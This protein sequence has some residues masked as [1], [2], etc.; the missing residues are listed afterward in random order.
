VGLKRLGE[1]LAN[2]E[3][4]I[5]LRPD[6]IDARRYHCIVL[7]QSG[8]YNEA[9]HSYDHVV[10]LTPNDVHA[11]H[12][13]GH[14]LERL[15]RLVEALQCYER[16]VE[17]APDFADAHNRHIRVLNKLGR[18]DEALVH[19]RGA[20]K[21]SP[22]PKFFYLEGLCLYELG[23]YE[24]AYTAGKHIDPV[25][26]GKDLDHHEF[27]SFICGK[28]NRR[29]EGQLHGGIALRLKDAS[30]QGNKYYAIPTHP[31]ADPQSGRKVISYTLYGAQ[32]R[33]C[34][35]AIA[36]CNAAAALLPD[37]SCR[38]YVDASVP[39]DVLRR[40]RAKGAEVIMVDDT[41]KAT[42][43]PLMWR[44]LVADDPEV[45]RFLLRDADSLIGQRETAAVHAWL[46][47]DRWFH[48]MRDWPGHCELMLAGMWGGCTGVIP[49]MRAE[50]IDFLQHDGV[51]KSRLDIDQYFLRQRLWPTVRQS[52]LSHDSQFSFPGNQAFPPVRDAIIDD[53]AYIGTNLSPGTIRVTLDAPDGALAEW[54][55]LNQDGEVFCRYD[56]TIRGGGCV[57]YFPYFLKRKMDSGELRSRV[58]LKSAK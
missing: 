37:W 45:S 10:A 2:I 57:L 46:E 21:L 55:L 40:L 1:A 43:H 35:V 54:S 29:E 28:T 19:A 16:A 48:L 39:A 24:D 31:P 6:W 42:I 36:N 50:I 53:V 7:E 49:S 58:E 44:F 26:H 41:T 5:T 32:P 56:I 25:F 38:F 3:N 11:H 9:L 22:H 14:V 20:Q 17:L 47:S 13:R 34:E 30:V 18:H 12:K 33:Y 15:G 8:R 51:G 23:R 52:V 4:V 27:M